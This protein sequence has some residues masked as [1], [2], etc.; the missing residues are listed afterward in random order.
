MAAAANAKTAVF[1]LQKAAVFLRM[2]YNTAM[3]PFVKKKPNI[4]LTHKPVLL[5]FPHQ[6]AILYQING[7]YRIVFSRAS[8]PIS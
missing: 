8:E 3:K 1:L 4:P 7:S 6:K 2:S 5:I